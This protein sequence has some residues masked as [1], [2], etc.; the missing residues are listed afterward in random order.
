M[1]PGQ[2]LRSL[3]DTEL[4]ATLENKRLR[5]FGTAGASELF[6]RGERWR[7]M[8]VRAPREGGY[9]VEAGRFCISSASDA[10]TCRRL[11][12]DRQGA[13]FVRNPHIESLQPVELSPLDVT[14]C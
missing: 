2:H 8:D 11:Y 7:I 6:C 4:Q 5:P 14:D 10:E 9:R 1:E 13:Y 12:V 3:R